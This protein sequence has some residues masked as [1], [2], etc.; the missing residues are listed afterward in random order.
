MSE[1]ESGAGTQDLMEKMRE[2]RDAYL[3][4]WSK[5]L[6]ETVNS[7][8]YAEASGAALNSFL[9]AAAPFKEP[10][11]EAMLRTLQQL[12]MPT[13]ADFESLAGRFTNVE[14][15]L[16]NLDAKLDRLEKLL[17]GA[18][19]TP[20]KHASS[21]PAQARARVAASRSPKRAKV[22]KAGRSKARKGTR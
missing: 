2:L 14:M 6:I 4:T 22:A 10:A 11:T 7:E 16:D 9:N 5:H 19:A 1:A 8:T 15:Q 17:A 13:S 21:K 20:P 18:K 12:H 3:E